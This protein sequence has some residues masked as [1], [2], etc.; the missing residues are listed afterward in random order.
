MKYYDD[1]SSKDMVP[2]LYE[3][4]ITV[5]NVT[6]LLAPY[7][8]PLTLAA[9]P[10]AEKHNRLMVAWMS[11]SDKLVQQGFRYL[12][13]VPAMASTLWYSA[14]D[15]V[16]TLDPNA[17]I[18]IVYKED[19]FNTMVAKGAYNQSVKLGLNVVF[20]RSYPTTVTDFTPLFTALA[21]TK[22]DVILICSHES[23]GMLAFQQ[24]SQLNI[25]A[26]LIGIAVAA[27][28]PNFYSNFKNL[29]EGIIDG[30]HWAPY[31]K[32][33]PQVAASLGIQWFGPTESEFLDLFHSI[34]GANNQPSYHAAAGTAGLLVLV[35]A[36]EKAQSLNQDAVRSAFNQLNLM[37]LYGLFKID[38][39]TGA[40]LG[41]RI[42]VGQWQNGTFQIV[43][44]PEAQ[45][46]KPAYP[47]PTWDQKRAGAIATPSA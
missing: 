28:L 29:A 31:V 25:N 11:N 24:L 2:S 16:K 37:T 21:A 14:L 9:A 47:I 33:S 1:Q 23:D 46:S 30:T 43:W 20:F 39:L 4:L 5:D 36:I 38:P 8:S 26:K 42:L 15:M 40:Q 10:V 27:S 35:K 18:A 3:R 41:H 45:S 44:P 19:E 6:F 13:I 22:P 17:T 32:Y 7:G 12:V 34:A